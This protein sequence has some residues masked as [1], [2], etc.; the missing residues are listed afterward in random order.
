MMQDGLF[1][2]DSPLLIGGLFPCFFLC[3]LDKKR[4]NKKNVI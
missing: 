4:G 2:T 1:I 3:I